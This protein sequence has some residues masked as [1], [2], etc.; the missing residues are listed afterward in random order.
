MM[1]LLHMANGRPPVSAGEPSASVAD[2]APLDAKDGDGETPASLAMAAAKP[3][4]AGGDVL[5]I[6]KAMARRDHERKRG[7]REEL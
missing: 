3:G 1:P 6:L 2:G 4:G 5:E 7:S